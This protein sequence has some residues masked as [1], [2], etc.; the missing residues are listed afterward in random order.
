MIMKT[1]CPLCDLEL[2][3]VF[4]SDKHIDFECY[5]KINDCD[6]AHYHISYDLSDKDFSEEIY[7][8]KYTIATYYPNIISIYYSDFDYADEQNFI[9]DVPYFN[10]SNEQD[11]SKKLDLI[12]SLI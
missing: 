10:C 7:L 6:Y 12:I 3:E 11:I 1:H 9:T 2:I 5:T 4:K 8:K